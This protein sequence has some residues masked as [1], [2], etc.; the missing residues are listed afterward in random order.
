MI[1]DEVKEGEKVIREMTDKELAQRD[2]VVGIRNDAAHHERK[3]R[4]LLEKASALNAIMWDEIENSSEIL[5]TSESRGNA[6]GIRQ[7]GDKKVIVEFPQTNKPQLP[8]FIRHL[9][10]GGEC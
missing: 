3:A 5:E 2:E 7:S 1:F 9:L 6:I 8:D 10:G 4:K